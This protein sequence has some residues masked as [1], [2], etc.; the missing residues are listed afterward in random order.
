[1][2]RA[3]IESW[4]RYA[5][6]LAARRT[7]PAPAGVRHDGPKIYLAAPSDAAFEEIVDVAA[8]CDQDP[9]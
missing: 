8:T 5:G 6:H 3:A 9:A 4:M 7:V 2:M 1:M